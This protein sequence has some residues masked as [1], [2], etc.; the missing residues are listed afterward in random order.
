MCECGVEFYDSHNSYN[1]YD[2]EFESLTKNPEAVMLPYSVGTFWLEGR[3]YVLDCTCWHSRAETIKGFIDSHASAI[4]QYIT[5]EKQRKQ[6]D[7][8]A[9]PTVG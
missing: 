2:G 4:A 3:E 6:A 8:D 1:W 5:L 7:A 9:A